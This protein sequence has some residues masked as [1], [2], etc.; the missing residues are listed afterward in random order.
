[1]KHLNIHTE[2]IIFLNLE[3]YDLN[4]ENIQKFPKYS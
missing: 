1:M 3:S 4:D 2:K